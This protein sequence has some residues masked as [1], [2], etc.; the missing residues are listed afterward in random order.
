MGRNKC[1]YPK[2]LGRIVEVC[3]TQAAFAV[4]IDKSKTTVC[5]KINGKIPWNSDE[6][7][8]SC[9][10]LGLGTKDIGDYFFA[11]EVADVRQN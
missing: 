10:V 11:N 6:I 9:N 1:A 4:A 5:A 8:S 3:G 7:I 2:L